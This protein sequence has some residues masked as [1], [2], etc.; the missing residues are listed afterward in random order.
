V[1][2]KRKIQQ[3]S[4]SFTF[5]VGESLAASCKGKQGGRGGR[6]FFAEGFRFSA[7]LAA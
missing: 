2:I 6:P 5:F 4:G 7:H 3:M 1:T